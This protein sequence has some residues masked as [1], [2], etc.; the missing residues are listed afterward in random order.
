MCT[1]CGVPEAHPA[2]KGVAF[3]RVVRLG[4]GATLCQGLRSRM[5]HG[6]SACV[7]ADAPFNTH[8]FVGAGAACLSCLW[9]IT[10][11]WLPRCLFGHIR[12]EA[13]QTPAT[14]HAHFLWA[15]ANLLHKTGVCRGGLTA[16]QGA[17][18]FPSSL[19]RA[20]PALQAGQC[21]ATGLEWAGE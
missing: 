4:W 20:P 7:I 6:N 1:C 19:R 13:R 2:A 15:E 11:C 14:E 16:A 12:G 10:S 5:S 8:T 3:L 18:L 17:L 21:A 9:C